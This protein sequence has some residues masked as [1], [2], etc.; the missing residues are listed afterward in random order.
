MRYWTKRQFRVVLFGL[1][2]VASF[3]VSPAVAGSQSSNSSSNC[4][5]GR[6]SRVDSLVI[7]DRRGRTRSWQ[8]FEAWDERRGRSRVRRSGRDRDD[9]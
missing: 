4:S 6:C 1:V 8:R 3:A 7:E 9:D 2:A 5:N